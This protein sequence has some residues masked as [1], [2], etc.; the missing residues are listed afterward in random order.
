MTSTSPNKVL[1]EFSFR[2]PAIYKIEV[3]GEINENIFE[4]LGGMQIN[5]NRSQSKKTTSVLIGQ[6]NDQSALSGL[7]NTL[8]EY[9]LSILSVNLL[10]DA[11]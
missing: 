4:R 5:I 1:S 9:Q 7:L 8:Y 3:Q 11:L 10:K 6:I 2:K